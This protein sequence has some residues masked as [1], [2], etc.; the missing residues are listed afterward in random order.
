MTKRLKIVFMG[1]PQI[2]VSILDELVKH[3]DVICV[4]TKEPA[5]AKR[6]KQLQNSQVHN[7]A[8]ELG[9][10]VRHPKTFK[11]EQEQVNF[12]NLGADIAVVCAYGHI[13]P[14]SVLE[15]FHY[16]SINV[17]VSMLPKYRGAAPIERSIINGDSVTGVT[18]M[19]M[20]LKMDAGDILSQQEIEIPETMN[21]AELYEKVAVE[22]S[23][24]C[25]KTIFDMI[26]GD[27]N[28]IKQDEN[29][30]TFA[31]KILKEEFKLDFSKPAKELHNLV[32]GIYPFAYFEYE[33][34]RIGVTETWYENGDFG[35]VGSFVDNGKSVVCADGKLIFKR[36]KRAGKKEMSI[37]DFLRGFKFAI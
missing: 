11:D 17:H 7:R 21:V 32:R 23:K 16:K 37:D 20:V 27:I 24:L 25:I 34:E 31:P 10:V 33:G 6:G 18:I 22:G 26:S 8:L 30:V 15:A 19:E 3:H 35:E 14:T 9:I 12:K 5:P 13:L 2:A 4:Y 1:T 36:M 28:P 29:L